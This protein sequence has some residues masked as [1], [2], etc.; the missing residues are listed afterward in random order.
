MSLE[1]GGVDAFHAA[2]VRPGTAGGGFGLPAAF[3]GGD[4]P[5]SYGWIRLGG[6]DIGATMEPREQETT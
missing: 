6:S 1:R 5:A 3:R 4:C 2:T